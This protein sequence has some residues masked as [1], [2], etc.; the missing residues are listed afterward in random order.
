MQQ[1]LDGAERHVQPLRHGLVGTVLEL[2][3]AYG[4]LCAEGLATMRELLD[5]DGEWSLDLVECMLPVAISLQLQRE[6]ARLKT[7]MGALGSLFSKNTLRA[8]QD[9]AEDMRDA[10]RDA[11][12][13]SRDL[14]PLGRSVRN[15][16]MVRVAEGFDAMVAMS[17]VPSEGR[18]GRRGRRS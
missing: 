4:L 5:F 9:D 2:E 7:M 15:R 12:R 16:E 11:Y 1:V 13:E 10:I 6:G 18:R 17:G 8:L 14:D 3:E